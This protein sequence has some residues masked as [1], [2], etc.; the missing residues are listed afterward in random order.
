MSTRPGIGMRS[1][2][3]GSLRDFL[4]SGSL[5]IWLSMNAVSPLAKAISTTPTTTWLTW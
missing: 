4:M 1:S 3:S 5:G 2:T